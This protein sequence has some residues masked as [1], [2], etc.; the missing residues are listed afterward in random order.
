[1]HAVVYPRLRGPAEHLI[2]EV[3]ALMKAVF[4]TTIREVFKIYPEVSDLI[5]RQASQWVFITHRQI[6][7]QLENI[8]PRADG[9]LQIVA[10]DSTVCKKFANRDSDTMSHVCEGVS[11]SVYMSS[12]PTMFLMCIIALLADIDR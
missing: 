11:P 12:F 10:C 5:L 8:K 9:C 2:V 4:T 6:H 7:T 3:Q 1:M